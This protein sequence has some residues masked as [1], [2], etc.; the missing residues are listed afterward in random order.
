VIGLGLSFENSGLDLD[1]KIWH[2][3]HLW[4]K[5]LWKYTKFLKSGI[6]K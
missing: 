5:A 6:Y 4:Y 1:R 2:S 3:A